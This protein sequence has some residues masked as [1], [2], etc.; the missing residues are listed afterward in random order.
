M[1]DF[2]NLDSK[3]Y[4]LKDHVGE[5]VILQGM[6]TDK[7]FVDVHHIELD[8]SAV[9]SDENTIAQK[10]TGTKTM[11]IVEVISGKVLPYPLFKIFAPLS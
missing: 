4:S 6:Q 8:E 9:G 3:K 10:C 7:W 11:L 2:E 5:K 1:V